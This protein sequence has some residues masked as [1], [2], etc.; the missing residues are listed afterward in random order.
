[1]SLHAKTVSLVRDWYAVQG[2]SVIEVRRAPSDSTASAVSADPDVYIP[3]EVDFWAPADVMRR[4]ELRHEFCNVIPMRFHKLEFCDDDGN[5]VLIKITSG[6]LGAEESACAAT[7]SISTPGL[8]S[9]N[10]FF[11]LFPSEFAASLKS[12]TFIEGYLLEGIRVETSATR[13]KVVAPNAVKLFF[14]DSPSV[15]SMLF[16][17]W[18]CTPV[19]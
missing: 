1:M 15:Y 14:P 3:I 9:A 19:C 11:G 12:D 7:F 4:F 18:P 8:V 5:P 6:L 16:N 17:P 10:D 2:C 13:L